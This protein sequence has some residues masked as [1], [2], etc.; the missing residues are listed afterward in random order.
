MSG[1]NHLWLRFDHDLAYFILLLAIFSALPSYA[2]TSQS[3]Q[4]SATITPGCLVS[5]GTL[6]GTLNFGTHPSNANGNFNA[7]L[8]PNTSLTLAC[9]PGTVLSMSINGGNNYTTIRNVK[10]SGF[11]TLLSYLLY[12]DSAHTIPIGLNQNVSV[13]YSNS[14]NIIIPIYGVLQM[15]GANNPSGT[16]TDLLTVTL[17]W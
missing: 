13:S 14:N 15:N 11:S 1:N 9:T 2:I 6:F 12:A 5:G 17:S 4:V 10:Q 8:T 3:F 7:S 16:Y